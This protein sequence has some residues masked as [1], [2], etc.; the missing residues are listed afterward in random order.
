VSQ[1]GYTDRNLG[2]AQFTL[3][4]EA[5]RP[6]FVPS[7]TIDPSSGALPL[8]ASRQDARFGQVLL[9]DSRL[10]SQSASV[11][12]AANGITR[13][14]ITLQASYTFSHARDQSSSSEG[15]G[16]RGFAG[17]TAG[18]NPNDRQWARSD[19]ERR[20][21]LL[22]VVTWPAT[23]A[24][25]VTGI[26]RLTSGS[27]YTPLAGGD[28]NGDGSRNDRAFIYNPATA[29]DTAIANGMQRLLTSGS[30]GARKCLLSQMGTIAARNSCTGP[31]Q[32]SLDLQLNYRP[33]WG[34]LNRRLTVSVVTQNLLAGVDQLVHGVDN[35]HGWGQTV[36]PSSSLLSVHGF[37]PASGRF[38]YTVNERFGATAVGTNAIRIPFQI[39]LQLRYTLGSRGGPGGFG[40]FAGGFGGR[41]AAAG[42]AADA[43][44]NFA[45]LMP[46]PIREML[47]LK[48]GLRL[49]DDQEKQLQAISD[50]LTAQ[51]EAL[52]KVL[53]AEM[54]KMGANVD[55]AR[56]IAV[57][58]PRMEEARKHMQAAL[59]A[60][61]ALLTAEQWNYLPDHIK[62]PRAFGGPGGGERRGQGRR[63]PAE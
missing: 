54:A 7:T 55:G 44:R 20:H 33:A 16:Q 4:S 11:T 43:P 38:L 36:R 51:N 34:G 31:W 41:G 29:P 14:G 57:L 25:E 15:G 46:N 27:P 26:G 5:G 39:G 45:N 9:L 10:G 18:F 52:G 3:Q 62:N 12:F 1:S 32:P 17:Q 53:Q 35:L 6:V 61:K 23:A 48:I 2:P 21:S 28:I 30:A 50:S 47:G 42:A 13:G 60:A 59:D 49:S 37:D 56:M 19:F 8:S 58:R 63:P 22:G 40:G 24:L